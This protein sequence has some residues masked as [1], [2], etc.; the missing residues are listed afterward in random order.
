MI[1]VEHLMVR[2]KMKALLKKA[3]EKNDMSIFTDYI[4]KE[5]DA[6]KEIYDPQISEML[7]SAL[8]FKEISDELYEA[9]A[10]IDARSLLV[11]KYQ[12]LRF[13]AEGKI[14]NFTQL[15]ATN[16]NLM[17][18]EDVKEAF[19]NLISHSEL[20]Q[21][22]KY[23]ANTG[24]YME[25]AFKN[26]FRI[27][28]SD[29][30]IRRLFTI[31]KEN[32]SISD[33]EKILFTCIS[34][35]SSTA[36]YTCLAD[37]YMEIN[38]K[39]KLRELLNNIVE[40]KIKYN[41][42]DMERYYSYLEDYKM[43]VEFSDQN[44]PDDILLADAYYHLGYYEKSLKIYKY[45]YYNR[46]K[47]V[48]GRIV[49]I[50]YAIK[51]YYSLINYI[52]SIEKTEKA[53]RKFLLYKIEAEIA[54]DLYNEAE[55]D[56][57][58]YRL[59]YGE[60]VDVL[61]LL[62]KY[63]RA[64]DNHE[65]SYKTALN[66]I[67]KGS[68]GIDNYKIVVD[69]LYGNGEYGEVLSYIEKKNLINEFK[70]QYCSSLVY[71]GKM[72][73]AVEYI[74]KDKSLM[75]SGM[76]VDS[77]FAIAKNN[78][79]LGKLNAMS[80]PGTLLDMVILYIHGRKHIDYM[81]FMENVMKG[82]SL[83]GI[84]IIA[85]SADSNISFNRSYVRNLLGIDRYQIIASVLSTISSINNGETVEGLNDSKYFMYPITRA[86][87]GKKRDR[88]AS[89][90][91][92]SLYG[93]APD[94][95]Y[96][97]FRSCIEFH[98]SDF[99]DAVKHVDEAMSILDNVDFIA[100]RINIGL[101]K[102]E[103][104]DTYIKAAVNLGF[105]DIFGIV[106][107]FVEN[108]KIEINTEFCEFLQNLDINDLDL[109]RL[110]SYCLANYLYKLKFSALSL[111]YGGNSEDIIK[112][113]SILKMRSEQISINFL[114]SYKNKYY[115]SYIIL[116]SYYY[117]KRIMKKA[118]EYFNLA[119]IRNN[120]AVK[121]PLF[122]NLFMGNLISDAVIRAMETQKEW[123]HLMLYYYHRREYDK[124]REIAGSHYDNRKIVEFLI[125]HAWENM[126]LK[127]FMVDVFEKSQDKILGELLAAKF[128]ELELYENEI[129][130]LK[131]LVR[132]Y[133]DESIIF[134]RLVNALIQNGEPD[135]AL[136]ATYK[137]F[138]E[139]KDLSSFNRIVQ[140]SYNM[141]DYGSLVNIF[142]NNSEFINGQNIKYL[143][144]SQ[145]KLFNYTGARA[146]MHDY[147]SAITND[148]R[149][150]INSKLKSSYRIRIVIDFARKIFE[151]EYR[152]NRTS[153]FDEIYAQVPDY[154]ANDV[155][156]FITN[157]EAYSHIDAVEYNKQSINIIG[158][159]AKIGITDI[160]NIKIYHIY[161]VT[162]DAVKSKNF[163]VFIRRCMD[164]YYRMEEFSG[165]LPFLPGE[166]FH[167]LPGIIEII[168][169]YNLGLMDAIYIAG[170]I[171][172]GML[173]Q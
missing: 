25:D 30:E 147:D 149:G 101:S 8:K 29:D 117:S 22:V 50:N 24:L 86:L 23:L 99:A 1:A 133:P 125:T 15:I 47:N 82:K 118:L 136:E 152:E 87:I 46:D 5:K 48:L 97:Y 74:S 20:A 105:T 132:Y 67:E 116:S 130:I 85:T 153:S 19:E 13:Y 139:K 79:N 161:R 171:K 11:M 170:K 78:E 54:L 104:P 106:D 114:E 75:N 137:R 167:E 129:G 60:D 168:I 33:L 148:V 32:G 81:K 73:E 40:N 93:K 96:Y 14:D 169:K 131:N 140:V 150:S 122:K 145:I 72:E 31:F 112:H 166:N 10:Y 70:P 7:Y 69:Y 138:F 62:I 109:Y 41:Y 155:Y 164:G 165:G 44:V 156:E 127:G 124:V 61:E 55:S 16:K 63:Y 17:I 115:T 66:L 18:F 52:G 160:R 42:V 59:I 95:F 158:W 38:Q 51:D 151:N 56:I 12:A 157:N 35:T 159:L 111:L 6:I 142:N 83:A 110:K 77:I 89:A 91:L 120:N 98:N 162:G 80:E 49:E 134:D 135:R 172:K 108:H 84:Y 64:T 121:N 92:D 57:V 102:N 88:E 173:N 27:G 144:Y 100:L 4:I 163:Y 94:A 126:S 28:H 37:L 146:I 26:Y 68:K 103:N 76:V 2:K 128:D 9:L 39:D 53:N 123:F 43:V 107:S 21:S 143:I 34:E 45:I 154:L 90:I 119:Y 141:K 58:N 36:C 65:M 113:Y 3:T 71:Y